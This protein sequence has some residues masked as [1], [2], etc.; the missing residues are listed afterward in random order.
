M[1][2][3]LLSTATA[4]FLALGLHA[5]AQAQERCIDDACQQR[6]ILDAVADAQSG[7]GSSDVIAAPSFGAWGIDIQGM[8]RSAKPGDDF[9]EYV[10]GSWPKNTP[11]PA[12]RYN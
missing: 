7:A 11:I 3:T 9:F 8:D 1:N 6:L 4:T 12:D 2:K 5:T 10:N